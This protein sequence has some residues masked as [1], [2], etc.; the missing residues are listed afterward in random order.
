[1]KLAVLVTLFRRPALSK[2]VLYALEKCCGIQDVPI[3]V[4]VDSTENAEKKPMVEQTIEVADR[5][6]WEAN[7]KNKGL[8]IISIIQ[9]HPLGIDESKLAMFKMMFAQGYDA[10]LHLEDDMVPALD[11]IRYHQWAL[12]KYKDDQ[13]I[14]EVV[15]YQKSGEE[16]LTPEYRYGVIRTEHPSCWGWSIWKDRW[17]TVI[18]DESKYRAWAKSKTNGLFDHYWM[19][20]LRKH[21]LHVIQPRLARVQNLVGDVTT[22]ERGENW[23]DPSEQNMVGFNEVGSWLLPDHDPEPEEWHE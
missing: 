13:S 11:F 19:A 4:S 16:Y 7:T 14:L 17:Q 10:V 15:A 12:E 8:K 20:Y 1:M 23:R 3:F 6:W 2:K 21:E 5:W 22:S 9:N 18:G